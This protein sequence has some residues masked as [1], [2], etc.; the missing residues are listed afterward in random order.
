MIC[1]EPTVLGGI[2]VKNRLVMPPMAT[3]SCP[4]GRVGTKILSHYGRI[5]ESGFYGLV[6][7]EHAYVSPRGRATPFQLSA[8]SD[9][10]TEGL[11]KIADTVHGNGVPAVLQISHGGSR[12]KSSVTG[13]PP[14]GPSDTSERYRRWGCDRPEAMTEKDISDTVGDFAEAARRA[15]D[16]GFDGVEVHCAHGYLLN[17]FYSPLGNLRDDDYGGD[18]V[19]R[20]RM[21]VETVDAVK[22]AVKGLPVFLRF[23][24]EDHLPGGNGA[25]ESMAACREL[26]K[27][28]TDVFDV[29]GGMCGYSH[30]LGE[31]PGYF[32][33]SS[34]IVK[35]NVSAPVILTGGI[36]TSSDA[37]R[38]M[39]NGDA[40]AIGVGRPAFHR[41]EWS[42][43][44]YG[45]L[46]R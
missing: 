19:N 6:I 37:C 17:S 31:T 32:A 21:T 40:D 35:N 14:L 10:D 23:G 16:A 9:R 41:N 18:T 13:H 38:F 1:D 30:P 3:E 45:N 29:S 2:R 46:L 24:A 20:I 43:R 12:C 36:R 4:D 7:V 34:K 28:G 5:S 33:A 39:E 22:R 11:S 27:A 25:E 26:E 44:F 15:S 8:S 42:S